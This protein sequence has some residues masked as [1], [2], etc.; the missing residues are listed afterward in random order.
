MPK[1]K[2]AILHGPPMA[3]IPDELSAVDDILSKLHTSHDIG[4]IDITEED[5]TL[6]EQI[7]LK[8][9]H[10]PAEV[11]MMEALWTKYT[12]KLIIPT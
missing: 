9:D 10:T 4:E 1:D 8:K 7:V 6:M 5:L 2:D 11:K 12:S 3:R